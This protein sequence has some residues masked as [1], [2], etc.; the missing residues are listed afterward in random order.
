MRGGA[1]HQRLGP[2]VVVPVRAAGDAGDAVGPVVV[3]DERVVAAIIVGVE[4]RGHVAAAAPA[5]V[6][7]GDVF[8][9]PGLVAAVGAAEVGHGRAGVGGHV[10]DPLHRLLHGAAADVDADVG[11]ACRA[12]SQRSR[13][14][15]VPKWLFSTTP[16]QCVLIIDGPFLA[17]A[18][19]VLPVVLVG[20]AAARPAQLGNVE[21]LQRG[22]HVVAV[23]RG[24]WGWANLA[25][26]DALVDAAAEVLGELAVDVAVDDR[27]GAPAGSPDARLRCRRRI[28]PGT[29]GPPLLP[30]ALS[31][32]PVHRSFLRQS[33]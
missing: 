23:C 20:E 8:H 27:N 29:P 6:A 5:L 26:P 13:N 16:P 24:C 11:L 3:F 4:L 15:C 12:C 18:D 30:R 2:L 28:P 10:F 21:L 14:S 17:R 31:P 33:P 9:L 22:D 19:A 25:D 32:T 7:D 1:L